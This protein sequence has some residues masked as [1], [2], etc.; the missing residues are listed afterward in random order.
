[1]T[2][3]TLELFEILRG[4]SSL[5]PPNS[6][7]FPTRLSSS[8]IHDFFLTSILTSPHFKIFPPSVQYQKQFWKWAITHL[9]TLDGDEASAST[10]PR[11]Y[12]H[13]ISLMPPPGPAL[14]SAKIDSRCLQ[15]LPLQ[16]PPSQSYVTHFWRVPSEGPEYHV[17]GGTIN[18]TEYETVTLLESRTTIES[19]TTG[20]R[21]W[22]ASFVLSEYLINHPADLVRNKRILELGS[23]IGFLGIIVASLQQDVSPKNTSNIGL[24][25]SDINEDILQRC[26]ENIQLSSSESALNRNISYRIIDWSSALDPETLPSLY[27]LIQGEINAD[28]VL[29]ADLVFDPTLIPALIAT[30]KLCLQPKHV[31]S[32]SKTIPKMALI[33]VTVRNQNTLTT[34]L[35][36]A[37]GAFFLSSYNL[38]LLTLKYTGEHLRV[39]ELKKQSQT[40]FLETIENNNHD[41]VKLFRFSL[42]NVSM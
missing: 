32:T 38:P 40:L 11:I 16:V 5:V 17:P 29:G 28:L 42:Q 31:S 35:S 41:N 12:D 36:L 27:Q 21:T 1:M 14:G 24:C 9:E 15:G 10:D 7:I 8:L 26:K 34:F 18:T 19:G 23:G 6:L 33:S 30:I 20:L 39:E 22:L 13:Y 3:L 25:M 4:F 2:L 37:Q